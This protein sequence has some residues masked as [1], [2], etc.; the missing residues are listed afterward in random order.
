MIPIQRHDIQRL[1]V[2]PQS[3]MPANLDTAI[4]PGQMADLLAY[5]TH[6]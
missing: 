3:M 1:T 2:V 4:T 6:P 5:L